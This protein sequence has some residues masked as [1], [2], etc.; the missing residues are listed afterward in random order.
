MYCSTSFNHFLV[1]PIVRRS[2]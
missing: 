1:S 2:D